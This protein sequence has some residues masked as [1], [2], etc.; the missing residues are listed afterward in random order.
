MRAHVNAKHS[1]GKDGPNSPNVA[2]DDLQSNDVTGCYGSSELP[3]LADNVLEKPETKSVK[4]HNKKTL[5][6]QSS[7]EFLSSVQESLEVPWTQLLDRGRDNLEYDS[8]DSE[9]SFYE[10][11]DEL[12][13]YGQ[14]GEI[15]PEF[16]W[17]KLL[18]WNRDNYDSAD[19]EDSDNS[20]F[21]SK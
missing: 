10:S 16:P 17:T 21:C 14:E 3:K 5:S 18:A 2:I 19:S 4:I 7:D 1:I 8:D 12:S 15:I 20:D 9:L 11:S 6:T 13:F